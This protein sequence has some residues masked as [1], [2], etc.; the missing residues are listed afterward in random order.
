VYNPERQPVK[1]LGK[2]RSIPF[3][4]L[5]FSYS[6]QKSIRAKDLGLTPLSSK[7]ISPKI[8]SMLHSMPSLRWRGR[9][10]KMLRIRSTWR[11]ERG[12]L[13]QHCRGR[14]LKSSFFH[15]ILSLTVSY[16]REH[17]SLDG[18]CVLNLVCRHSKS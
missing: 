10:C 7:I 4:F 17:R 1:L 8:F 16:Y 11:L 18:C 5:T 15:L 3:P 13:L 14:I 9:G 6:R 2:S 12:T